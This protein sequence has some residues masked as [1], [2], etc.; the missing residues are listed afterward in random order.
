MIELIA[1][2]GFIYINKLDNNIQGKIIVLG[3]DESPDN[4]ELIP[5]KINIENENI[6]Y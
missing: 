6:E 4:W 5:E 3:V 2:D 1:P